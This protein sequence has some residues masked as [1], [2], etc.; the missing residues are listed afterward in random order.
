MAQNKHDISQFSNFSSTLYDTIEQVLLK[1]GIEAGDLTFHI[2][3][4]VQHGL[5]GTIELKNERRSK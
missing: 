2:L 1:Q 3:P 4:K 5:V